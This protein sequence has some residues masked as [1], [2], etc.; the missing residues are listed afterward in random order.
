MAHYIFFWAMLQ[1]S[2][3]TSVWSAV[4]SF[5]PWK[6][7][8]PLALVAF[9]AWAMI[10]AYLSLGLGYER[11]WLDASLWVLYGFYLV[12]RYIIRRSYSHVWREVIRE[13]LRGAAFLELIINTYTFSF[14]AEFLLIPFITF[15]SMLGALA[16][17]DE[18]YS[19]VAKLTDS[20]LAI[21]GLSVLA[22]GIVRA[23]S[24]PALI[25]NVE[26]LSAVSLPAAL[27]IGFVPLI[28]LFLVVSH[29]EQIFMRFDM[30]V[31][32]SR[33]FKRQAKWEIFK[34]LGFSYAKLKSFV[35]PKSAALMRV[36]SLKEVRNLLREDEQPELNDLGSR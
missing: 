10:Y 7:L 33:S 12:G 4:K 30:G 24:N 20:L 18:K 2:I 34:S 31:S 28:Y 17:T 22:Y 19:S 32:K 27:A 21:I 9:Y 23:V 13:N 6:I 5:F 26:I 16:N 11:I 25:R 8:T 14:L 29:Y 35:G 36:T 15:I 3:R 1:E